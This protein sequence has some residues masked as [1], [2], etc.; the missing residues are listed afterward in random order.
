MMEGLLRESPLISAYYF[1]F[2]KHH[3]TDAR[4]KLPQHGHLVLI[5][6]GG[7]DFEAIYN[8]FLKGFVAEKRLI[9]LKDNAIYWSD[10][11]PR[12]I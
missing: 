12:R 1:M 4:E 10:V 7:S 11:F 3:M 2:P 6:I 8:Q 9:S 5:S